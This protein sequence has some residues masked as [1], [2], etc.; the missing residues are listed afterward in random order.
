MYSEKVLD[1]FH[2]PRNVGEIQSA[3]AVVEVT[4]PVCGDVLK[5]WATVRDAV[6]TEARF[7]VAGCV[8]AVACGSYLTEAMQGQPLAE[9]AGITPDQIEAGLG[10][11][12]PASHHAA[13]LAADALK[14]LLE[15]LR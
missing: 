14:Q 9:L 3:T 1:H 5:L 11:L 12:P 7:K 13:V 10:G 2:R 8:P 6:V 15:K 4:N